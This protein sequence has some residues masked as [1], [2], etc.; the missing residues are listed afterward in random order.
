[1]HKESPKKPSGKIAPGFQE[2]E[3]KPTER[4]E[5]EFLKNNVGTMQD[6][7]AKLIG[8]KNHHSGGAALRLKRKPKN[9]LKNIQRDL[10]DVYTDG[11]GKIPD[12]TKLDRVQRPLWKTI[13][14]SLIAV[15]LVLFV[16]SAAG[17]FV[18]T[19]LNK[20][21][22]TN[23]KVSFRI[24]P[25]ISLSSGQESAYT[26]TITNKENVNLYNLSLV[27]TYPDSFKYSS[28]EPQAN[29]EKKNTWNFSVLK[30]G[31]TQQVQLKGTIIA[32]LDSTQTF[33]GTVTFKPEIIN[34][35][36]KQE[37]V[38]DLAVASSVIGL[39]ITG[40][41][42]TLAN[43]NIDY[44]LSYKNIGQKEV[45]NLELVVDY[46][47]GFNVASATPSAKDGTNNT[48]QIDKITT[49]TG[50]QIK[51]TGNYS[52]V[53]ESGNQELKARINL[54]QDNNEPFIQSE[55]S[56]TTA[57]IKDQL[58]LE[59]IIN[60]SAEDQPISFGD[61]L[62]Y[63]LNYKNTGQ[64]ELKNIQITAHL[65]S[66]ILD[67]N[68]FKDNNKGQKNNNSVTWTGQQIPKLLSLA[69]GDEGSI[70]WQIRAKDLSAIRDKNVNQFSVESY[71]EAKGGNMDAGGT[72]VV[73]GKTI[74]N[75]INSD[76]NLSVQPRYYDENN[77]PLGFGSIQPKTGESSTYNVKLSLNNNL[78]DI[79]DIEIN[80]V[81]PKGVAWANKSKHNTGDLLY[82]PTTRKIIWKI[83]RLPKT[84]QE[85]EADFNITIKPTD[86]DL[87][88]V[89][90]LLPEITLSAK[91]TETGAAINKSVKAVTTAF[92]DPILGQLSGIVE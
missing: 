52:G 20:E 5:S 51:I 60:G 90:V 74:V 82:N 1:M 24:D 25:P 13:I 67:W 65:N 10:T 7:L 28:A 38:V 22:F 86:D 69:P 21:N 2:T 44:L 77:I 61:L 91:D 56:I 26:I 17:F 18:F 75:S 23:E 33:K 48:W 30:S 8:Q 47:L 63:T 6:D 87:G 80:A 16:A 53:A 35:E 89:L 57:I 19:N 9:N 83:S 36:F 4:D 34:A 68:T 84:A 15:A 42:K 50:G 11:N 12:L 62:T 64:Q 39:D 14:Y 41:D 81:L 29:G 55:Q 40:P 3:I 92:T 43:Q 49:T 76:L 70:S 66:S 27:M 31:E 45:K 46:P 73:K 32:P 37:A 54:K 88:R 71:A 72:N 59:M 78:H 58:N 79:S 85:T